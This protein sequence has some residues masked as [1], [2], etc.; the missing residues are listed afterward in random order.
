MAER[1]LCP[2]DFTL[3]SHHALQ[4]A[5]ALAE[6]SGSTITALHVVP[7][8]PPAID[9]S[10]RVA[11]G[12]PVEDMEGLKAQV[13]RALQE[14][15]ARSPEAVVVR[16][17]PAAEIARLARSLP[18]DLIVMAS[19][20]RT[21]S[22]S[23]MCGS[24]T[25]DVLCH[26]PCALLSVPRPSSVPDGHIPFRHILCAVD[27]SPASLQ[28][29]R[30]AVSLAAATDRRLLVLHVLDPN[31][32]S[33]AVTAGAPS[34]AP[35]GPVLAEMLKR[36]LR[37]AVSAEGPSSVDVTEYVTAGDPA[38]E[39][40]RMAEAEGCDLIV[41][42]AHRGNPLSCTLNKVVRSS[43]CAVLTIG[44]EHGCPL[45]AGC[46]DRPSGPSQ[47]QGAPPDLPERAKDFARTIPLSPGN[48]HPRA[49][50]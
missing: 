50:R 8:E 36:R 49:A 3:F 44:A 38:D 42:G 20:G 11:Q 5:V 16:G 14:A 32:T 1:I 15:G 35:V 43:K 10:D 37:E 23:M 31:G 22:A 46:P 4:W 24:V 12:L 33:Q 39:I 7:E 21:G 27:F 26:S 40:L 41:I 34:P 17:D 2:I 29:L 30:R 48:V 13:L 19:H 18:A 45:V 9:A 28:A 25:T 6:S 47:C